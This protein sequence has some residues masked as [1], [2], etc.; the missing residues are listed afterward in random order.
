LQKETGSKVHIFTSRCSKGPEVFHTR[1]FAPGYVPN[2]EDPVCGTAH[3]ILTPYWSKKLDIPRGQEIEAKQVSARG[4]VLKLVWNPE[5]EKVHLKG[6]MTQLAHGQALVSVPDNVR[7]KD[8][9][10]DV[11]L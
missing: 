7:A 4:G 6:K 9:V 10:V 1:M 11:A 8:H 5:L 2:D 3:C